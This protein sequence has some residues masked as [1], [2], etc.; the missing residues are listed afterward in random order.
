MHICW[1]IIYYRANLGK[2]EQQTE[3]LDLA[4]GLNVSFYKLIFDDRSSL[5]LV[6]VIC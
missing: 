5:K 3:C 4:S 2:L 6:P 1:L